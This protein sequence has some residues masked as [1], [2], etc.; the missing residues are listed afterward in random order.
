MVGSDDEELLPTFFIEK[1]MTLLAF[2]IGMGVTSV[3]I[4]NVGEI[5]R[6]TNPVSP[7][8]YTANS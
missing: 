6:N 2:L 7:L 3:I 1:F 4:G 8:P 5:V